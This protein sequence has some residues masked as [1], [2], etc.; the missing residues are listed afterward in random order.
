M[1]VSSIAASPTDL[2]MPKMCFLPKE[3]RML[4]FRELLSAPVADFY[5]QHEFDRRGIRTI[6]NAPDELREAVIEMMDCL[7]GT[8]S[9]SADDDE[10]QRRFWMLSAE[11]QTATGTRIYSRVPRYFLRKYAEFL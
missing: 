6:D 2:A 5:F 8:I 10:L 4:H 11:S 7:D 3:D 9:Y 1:P